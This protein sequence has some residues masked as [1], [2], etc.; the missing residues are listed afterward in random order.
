MAGSLLHRYRYRHR[1]RRRRRRL[2]RH[3]VE[4]CDGVVS[5]GG[6]SGLVAAPHGVVI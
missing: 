6:G 4:A 1:H 5:G 3:L 2:R